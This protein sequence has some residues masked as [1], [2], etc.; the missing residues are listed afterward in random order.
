MV[1]LVLSLCWA[2]NR[3]KIQPQRSHASAGVE[4]LGPKAANRALDC[5]QLVSLFT[6]QILPTCLIFLNILEPCVAAGHNPSIS[7]YKMGTRVKRAPKSYPKKSLYKM[8]TWVDLATCQK[9]QKVLRISQKKTF[10]RGIKWWVIRVPGY[11]Y[12]IEEIATGICL[13]SNCCW[14]M[15]LYPIMLWLVVISSEDYLS[16]TG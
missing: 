2:R 12:F 6:C 11:L 4:I 16:T 15:C 13:I 5:I 7:L 10:Y 14:K 1:Q 9:H 3:P 8:G